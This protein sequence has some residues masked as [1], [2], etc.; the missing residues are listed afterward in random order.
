MKTVQAL[1]WVSVA[2]L[3]LGLAGCR[4]HR[5][6]VVVQ[7]PVYAQQP[8]YVEQPAYVVVPGP[9]PPLVVEPQ[10]PRPGPGFIWIGGCWHW[11]GHRYGWIHGRWDRPPHGGAVWVGPRYEHFE[12]GYRY[13]P[14]H[15]GE[16]R[17]ERGREREEH[18]ERH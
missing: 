9:P 15:W 13:A 12:R 17:R 1:L 5:E 14:G 10:P 16:E 18:R 8:V 2:V 7:Q 4:P 3:A 6:A 11:D